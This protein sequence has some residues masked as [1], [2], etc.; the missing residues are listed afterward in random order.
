MTYPLFSDEYFMN[1]ALK[2]AARALEAD[3]IPVGAVVVSENQIVAR[4]YNQ[5]QTLLDVTAHAE[6]LAITAAAHSL[7]SKY[8]DHCTLFVTLEPC[9]M[10][11]SATAWSH[12]ARLVYGAADPKAGYTTII[13][14]ILHPG[15]QVKKGVLE[16]ECSRLL[17]DFFRNK[18]V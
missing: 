8:L 1:E 5:T 7:G 11:G 4:A 17:K 6:M 10:C 3:E 13:Q 14:D 12:L 2:E 16:K 9:I 18:R 15:T